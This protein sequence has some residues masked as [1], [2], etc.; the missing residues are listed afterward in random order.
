MFTGI[1]EPNRC[2][3]IGRGVA[4]LAHVHGHCHAQLSAVAAAT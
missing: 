3:A 4:V 2:E 1:A